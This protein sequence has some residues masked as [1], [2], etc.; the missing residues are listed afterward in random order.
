MTMFGP[1]DSH[2]FSG[3]YYFLS[4]LTSAFGFP[5]G[6]STVLFLMCWCSKLGMASGKF[7][8]CCSNKQSEN[9]HGLEYLISRSCCQ[10][11]VGCRRSTLILSFGTPADGGFILQRVSMI[12]ESQGNVNPY[13]GS[14]SFCTDRCMLIMPTFR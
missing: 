3:Q 14:L 7:R 2:I 12:T 5:T 8:L 4:S 1:S 6:G 10:P 13:S 11:Q 9:L